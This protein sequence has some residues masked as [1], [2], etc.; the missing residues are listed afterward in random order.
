MEGQQAEAAIRSPGEA[1]RARRWFGRSERWS[2]FE[3]VEFVLAVPVDEKAAARIV[4]PGKCRARHQLGAGNA[5]A[6]ARIGR[7]TASRG[8]V[9]QIYGLGLQRHWAMAAGTIKRVA[10]CRL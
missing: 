8:A 9:V 3:G 7:K 10:L 5:K 6:R 4:G 2:R 1:A